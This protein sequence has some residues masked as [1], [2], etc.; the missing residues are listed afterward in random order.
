MSIPSLTLNDGHRIPQIGLGTWPLKDDELPE[1]I[2]TALAKGYRHI[3]TAA[4]YGNESGVGDGI[5]SS[6]V[7]REDLFLTT[8][9]PND[10]HGFDEAR[11]AAEESLQRLGTDYVD[12]LL[13]HWPMPQVDRYVETWK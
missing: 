7:D 12:L 8:K 2:R 1:V 3:D 10:S 5:R 4:A 6:D 11:R 13:I 9:V